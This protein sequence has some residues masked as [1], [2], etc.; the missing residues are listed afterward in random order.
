MRSLTDGLE[1]SR[2][3]D[4]HGAASDGGGFREKLNAAASGPLGKIAL[5]VIVV[6]IG[7][8]VFSRFQ[9]ATGP[10]PGTFMEA[11]TRIMNPITGEMDWYVVRAGAT[12]PEG[13]YPVV[14]CW[15]DHPED[16]AVPVVLNTSIF[17]AG[18]PRRDEPTICPCGDAVVV[19]RNPKPEEFFGLQPR[20]YETGRAPDCVV[21][22]YQAVMN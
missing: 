15:E 12:V 10:T 7:W 19:P 4:E 3:Q 11:R 6:I 8:F 21:Q 2:P 20:D 16:L 5:V 1:D 14:Y 13:F 9:S 17:P 18:D 22:H